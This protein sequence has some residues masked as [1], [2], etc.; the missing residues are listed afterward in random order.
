M[1]SVLGSLVF[2]G[3]RSV[4]EPGSRTIVASHMSRAKYER[5]ARF[6]D[7]LD[8]YF[9][10][11]RYRALR[12]QLFEGASGRLLDA[13]LGTGRNMPYYPERTEVVGIDLSP[14]MLSRAKS[15]RDQ[16]GLKTG[17]FVM[18]VMETAFPD[19]YFDDIV[20]TFL[21]CVLEPD[22]QM[23]ALRELRRICKPTGSIRI[24]EYEWPQNPLQRM[25][26]RLWAP[27]VRWA[28]GA[29]FDRNTEQ[30]MEAAGPEVVAKR[31]VYR[32]VIK[33]I[34][35]RPS[36]ERFPFDGTRSRCF[37]SRQRT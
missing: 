2:P 12:P 11:T 16:L 1:D 25:I 28:Y 27:W 10:T 4:S 26:M 37:R 31:Y 34:I 15:R 35:A 20:A 13:G 19:R 14:A 3:A 6:Y 21:F 18:D 32:D 5:I 9:E 33:L 22:Q 7:L 24:I 23:P 36:P 29:A 17:L 30:Y 8:L